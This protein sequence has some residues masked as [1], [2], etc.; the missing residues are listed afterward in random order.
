LFEYFVCVNSFN[1]SINKLIKVKFQIRDSPTFL[2][3]VPPLMSTPF[4]HA[5]YF[6]PALQSQAWKL[7][8]QWLG[9]C[10]YQL[11]PLKQPQFENVGAELFETLTRTPRLY[12][13]HATLKAPFELNSNATL[14]SLQPAFSHLALNTVN[15]FHLPLKLVEIGD[16]LALVPSQPSP[17]LQQL[18]EDCVRGLHALVLPLSDAELK[19]RTGAGLTARQTELLHAWTYPYVMEQFRFHLT[20]SESLKNVAP[21][22]KVALKA[23]AQEWF[24]PLLEQGLNIDAVTWFSQDEQ[25]GDF[26]CVERFE[27]R[28]T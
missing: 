11:T 10:A 9:R 4:R 17:A 25:H 12:G 14:E 20:L 1:K 8:S 27:L 7:G 5:A 22:V 3:E 18:A 6:A 19:R 15:A 26:R 2:S 16:F 21:E 13:W 28:T 23:A 24:A